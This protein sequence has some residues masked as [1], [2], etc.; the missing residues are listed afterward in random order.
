MLGRVV[1]GSRTWMWT[2][3]APAL[4]ASIADA[5][6]CCGVTGTAGLRDGVSADPVTAQA[7]ITLRCMIICRCHSMRRCASCTTLPHFAIS[8]LMRAPNSSGLFATGTKPS[9][10]RCCRRPPAAATALTISRCSRSTIS[11]GVRRRR[12][13]AGEGVGFLAGVAGFLHGR[14]VGEFRAALDREHGERAQFPALDI[15][16]R[17]RQGGKGDLGMAADGRS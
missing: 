9:F 16:Q 8:L 15:A 13:D 5:A 3:A 1:F 7:I 6:I 2:M 17:R 14:H 4:A 11:F 12:H 10:M